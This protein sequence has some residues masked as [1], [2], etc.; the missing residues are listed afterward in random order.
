M[1][2]FYA[3]VEQRDNPELRGKPIAVG[4]GESRGVLTTASYEARKFGVRSAMP[5]YMAK[6]LC[7]EL[8]F[9]PVRFDAYRAV[10]EQIRTI[11]RKYTDLI[12]PLSFDEAYLDVT[13]N[14]INEPVAT[15]VANKI[16]SEIYA[17][18][19][20]TCSA[21]VSYCK[22][23]AKVASDFNKPNGICIIKPHQAEKFLEELP[24]SKFYG[25]GKVTA[26]KMESMGIHTGADLK[27]LSRSEM[28]Q[29]FGKTGG[30]YYNIVRGKDDRPVVTSRER[31]SLAVERTLEK[32]LSSIE[33]IKSVLDHILDKFFERLEKYKSYGKT[34]TL[35][36]KTHDFKIITRSKSK[37]YIINDHGEIKNIAFALL[38]ENQSNFEKIRL[39]GLAMSNF[40]QKPGKDIKSSQMKLF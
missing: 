29:R 21:G 20:L 34:I 27:K 32:D 8:I 6:Q 24:V 30:F 12:E 4:G 7:P 9:V 17:T 2:A 28:L 35:K 31:K 14:K 37:T 10:S 38:E 13:E 3:S 23:I 33:D 19:Q 25:V 36:I 18:T 15:I 11:F 1:D 16:R 39:I 5:G 26:A 22:F 40:K